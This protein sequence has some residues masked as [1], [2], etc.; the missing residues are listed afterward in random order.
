MPAVA[1][2]Y[3]GRSRQVPLLISSSAIWHDSGSMT[4]AIQM[5]GVG[6]PEVLVAVDVDVPAPGPG[7]V[8]IRHTTMGVNFIDIYH[9]TGLYQLP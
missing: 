8:Q 3:G 5:Q 6:G 9:R 1:C 7:E 4:V 2:V